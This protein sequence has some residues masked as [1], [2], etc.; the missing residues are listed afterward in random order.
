MMNSEFDTWWAAFVYA[1]DHRGDRHIAEAAWNAAIL[2]YRASKSEPTHTSTPK[3]VECYHCQ[4]PSHPVQMHGD[5]GSDGHEKLVPFC[6]PCSDDWF[7]F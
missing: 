1:D 4:K 5:G 6:V 3:L 2:V 7:N